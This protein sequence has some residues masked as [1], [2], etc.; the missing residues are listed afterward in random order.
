MHLSLA[1]AARS[2]ASGFDRASVK[3]RRFAS[4]QAARAVQSKGQEAAAM[5]QASQALSRDAASAKR[6]QTAIRR[7][8]GV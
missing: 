5:L 8:F 2:L 6:E 3:A 7:E 4:E 1:R